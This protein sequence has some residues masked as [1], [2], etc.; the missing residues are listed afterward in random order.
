MKESSV[1]PDLWLAITPQPASCRSALSI[2]GCANLSAAASWQCVETCLGHFNSL[3]RLCDCAY[4]ID[5]QQ[6]G[7]ARL[8]L[9]GIFDSLRIGDKEIIAHNLQDM[10]AFALF[11]TCS[12][13]TVAFHRRDSCIKHRDCSIAG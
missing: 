2:R 6:K 8:L 12:M 7:I 5:L 9:N 3:D 1:S 10:C 11:T 13:S 4:L